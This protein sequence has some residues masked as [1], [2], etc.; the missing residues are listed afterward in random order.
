MHR[1]IIIS[2]LRLSFY[3]V[4]YNTSL[5]MKARRSITER[6]YS[7]CMHVVVR[8]P[9]LVAD[10]LLILLPAMGTDAAE[11]NDGNNEKDQ[12]YS[13]YGSCNDAC[14]VWGWTTEET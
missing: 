8:V 2:Y 13:N 4:L 10:F 1:V 3:P 9:Y 5:R 7:I 6:F 11:E 14:S 12:E